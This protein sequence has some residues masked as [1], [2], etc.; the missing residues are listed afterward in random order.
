MS[1]LALPQS[2]KDLLEELF[3]IFPQCRNHYEGSIHEEVSTFHSVLLAV[4]PFF[5]AQLTSFSESQLRRFGEMISV[6]VAR[7]GVLE[8]AFSTCLLEHLHQLKAERVMRP[9]LTKIARDKTHA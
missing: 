9:Y 7:D 6:A 1:T 8:N 2:P 3:T 4:T 5:G